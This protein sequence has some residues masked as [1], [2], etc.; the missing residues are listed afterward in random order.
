MRDGGGSGREL[1]GPRD[2]TKVLPTCM[3]NESSYS[4][5]LY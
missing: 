3:R 5:E 1:S 2:V 4:A